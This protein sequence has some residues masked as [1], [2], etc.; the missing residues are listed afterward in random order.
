MVGY[1]GRLR[2][3]VGG[4]QTLIMALHLHVVGR[5]LCNYNQGACATCNFCDLVLGK[6]FKLKPTISF[7]FHLCFLY[8]QFAWCQVQAILDVVPT[9]PPCP[10]HM[11]CPRKKKHVHKM[12]FRLCPLNFCCSHRVAYDQRHITHVSWASLHEPAQILAI[13]QTIV[14]LKRSW[15]PKIVVTLYNEGMKT[16][17]PQPKDKTEWEFEIEDMRGTLEGN[18]SDKRVNCVFRVK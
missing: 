16:Y 11:C 10:R 12:S 7:F 2:L 14:T 5:M 1:I 13:F 3:V 18:H 9:K 15:L 8:V 4:A 6:I 17:R